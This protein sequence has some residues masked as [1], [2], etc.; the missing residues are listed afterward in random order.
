MK[1]AVALV[2]VVWQKQRPQTEMRPLFD[3]NDDRKWKCD[4]CLAETTTAN[5]DATAV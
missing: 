4:R 2:V 3:R 1:S 5:E